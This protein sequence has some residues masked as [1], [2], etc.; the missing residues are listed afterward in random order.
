MDDLQSAYY[1]VGIVSAVLGGIVFVT[2]RVRKR[3]AD[4]HSRIDLLEGTMVTQ[5]TFRQTIHD[6][7][8]R[9]ADWKTQHE[10]WGEAVMARLD[11]GLGGLKA[12]VSQIREVLLRAT[13]QRNG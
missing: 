6:L 4:L 9:E 7:I 3:F 1:I 10:K 12:E 2:A 13:S 5:E 11:D 8:A